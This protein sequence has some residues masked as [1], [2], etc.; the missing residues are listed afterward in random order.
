[1]ISCDFVISFNSINNR[2]A[3]CKHLSLTHSHIGDTDTGYTVLS[4]HQQNFGHYCNQCLA[5]HQ[6][7]EV[8]AVMSTKLSYTICGG[9]FKHF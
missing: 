7:V 4:L 9:M 8:L 3:K 5:T 6:S 1:M 2:L